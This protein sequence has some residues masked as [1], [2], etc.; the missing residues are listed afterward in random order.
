MPST[1]LTRTFGS[2]NRKKF[3]LSMWVKLSERGTGNNNA[4][5]VSGTSGDNEGTIT[6]G[7]DYRLSWTEYKP[8]SGTVGNLTPS[9]LFR[10][11][12]AWLHLVFAWDSTNATADDRMKIWINGVEETNFN[13]RT[14]PSLNYDAQL[15][16]NVEHNIGRQTWNSSGIFNGLMSHIHFCDGYSYSASDFGETDST[17]GEWKIKTS[18]SVS[19]G[20]T[21]F[22]ILKD[23]NT[24]TD[25]S[26]NSNNFTVGGGTLTKTEDSP[27]NIF[28]TLNPLA[29]STT[30]G[31]Y[32][33]GNLTFDRP[34]STSSWVN[35]V[36]TLGASSGKYYWEYKV[37]D[38]GN[39]AN[40]CVI[41]F[42]NID[43]S[44]FQNRSDDLNQSSN[45]QNIGWYPGGNL[46]NQVSTIDTFN[47]YTDGDI[48][49]LA[50][51]LDNSYLYWGKNG[52]W[53][54]SAD[55]TSGATG[56]GGKATSLIGTNGQYV[57]SIAHREDGNGQANF[58]NGYFGTTAV[59]SAGTNASGNGIFEYDVP[60]GYTALSTK[61]LNL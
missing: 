40:G 38:A 18:P 36:S 31:N 19:Y 15:N 59:S 16:H 7:S 23:G 53:E 20:T 37:I 14:N 27:S 9:R 26:G 49:Q 25:Q 17:T 55:P 45:S 13:S 2:G 41:G 61:G 58:G 3:T 10:D 46:F 43:G 35:T 52:T 8:S 50:M 4:L 34:G 51:D 33:N 22:W 57:F 42:M 29:R 60:T 24:V 32:S 56:T 54:N 11:F 47:T 39:G 30:S 44:D 21:G 28:A 6:F 5:L 48:I 1:Y 12:N